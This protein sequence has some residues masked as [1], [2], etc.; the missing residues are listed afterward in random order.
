MFIIG[1][2]VS[3]ANVSK[4]EKLSKHSKCFDPKTHKGKNS[5]LKLTRLRNGS[6]CD[7]EFCSGVQCY[8][9]IF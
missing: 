5:F 7:K 2:E 1:K 8:K 9:T 4:S 6:R 3:M